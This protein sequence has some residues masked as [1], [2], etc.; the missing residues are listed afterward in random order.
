MIIGMDHPL[1]GE[2]HLKQ[3]MLNAERRAAR[4]SARFPGLDLGGM[5]RE[6]HQNLLKQQLLLHGHYMGLLDLINFL[7]NDRLFP[8]YTPENASRYY[9]HANMLTLNGV[10]LYQYLFRNGFEPELV[11]NFSGAH[12]SDL[13]KDPPLAVCISSTLTYLDDIKAMAEA[14]KACDPGIPVIVGGIL[15]KKVLNAGD[16]LAPQTRDWISTFRGKVDVF[17]VEKCG[18]E[19]LIHVL[20]RMLDRKILEDVP[21]LAFFDGEGR[22]VFT[23]RVEEQHHVDGTAIAWDKIP[24]RYLPNTVSVLT[25]RGCNY[26]C[27]FCNYRRWFP[28]VQYKSI[29]VLRE[30]LR[31]IQRLG[32][33]RHIR[34]ADDNLTTNRKHL[35]A[36]LGMMLEEKFH[37]TWSAHARVNFL[38]PET[39]SRMRQAGCDLL[40]MG[41]ESGSQRILDYM[42][43]RITVEQAYSA[44]RTLADHGVDSQSSF[45]VGYPG[46]TRESFQ[47]TVNLIV[48]TGLR[49][50]QS[51]LFFYSKDMAVHEEREALG[52]RGLGRAWRHN[53]MDAVEASR[54]MADMVA[55]IKTGFTDGQQNPWETYKILR[56]EGYS[57]EEIFRL[58]Q[59][60]RELQL[61]AAASGTETEDAK[62]VDGILRRME[63][64]I[65]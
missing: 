43:K 41:I 25:S 26:R 51:Y 48:E 52:L 37:F 53:T 63:T 23:P 42:D 9:L 30:E 44:V 40:V 1:D 46:E 65:H 15:V 31:S 49:Y 6:V 27:R 58:H 24:R 8:H 3:K 2:Q 61:K 18:E 47:E 22:L 38:D 17:V 64:M 39:V 21:N 29:E 20:D 55:M 16:G 4:N 33:V 11:S 59:L 35:R 19:T 45:I 12:L 62:K 10:Y 50:W 34:F 13:L 14:I 7:K 56:G 28:K 54:L 5:Q 32:F 60:K 36:F 57:R